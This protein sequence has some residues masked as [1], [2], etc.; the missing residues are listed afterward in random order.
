MLADE[1]EDS[2]F[3]IEPSV[4]RHQL[5]VHPDI[6]YT[7][8]NSCACIA[9]DAIGPSIEEIGR[10]ARAFLIENFHEGAN[11]GLCLMKSDSVPDELRDF[12]K[13]AQREVIDIAEARNLTDIPD[14]FVWVGGTTGQGCIGALAG[15]G[16]RSTGNDGRFIELK[17]IRNIEGRVSVERIL[18]DSRIVCVATTSDELL[19]IHEIIDTRDWVRPSLRYGRPV[20]VVA[21]DGDMWRPAE[22]RKREE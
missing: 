5:L 6:P 20:L 13:R 17:G 3:L 15:I 8:H 22:R 18:R 1:L 11:P 16:L 4:T 9:G 12:G 7:S 14:L 21:R 10:R 19:D 2:G